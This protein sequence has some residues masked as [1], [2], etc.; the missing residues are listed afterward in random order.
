[1][2]DARLVVPLLVLRRVVISVLTD[3]AVLACALDPG[4]DLLA[5]RARPFG[6]LLLEPVVG[7]LRELRWSHRCRL[8][9]ASGI[10]E[11][12]AEPA[13]S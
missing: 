6:E 10:D 11:G 7:L 3:V 4:G 13:V 1:L 5:A 9:G 2:A 8:P 12:R